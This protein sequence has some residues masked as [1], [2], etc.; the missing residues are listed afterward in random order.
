VGRKLYK[1]KDNFIE[2]KTVDI[3]VHLLTNRERLS[4]PRSYGSWTL[5]PQECASNKTKQK[6]VFAFYKETEEIFV[7]IKNCL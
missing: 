2:Q 1:H 6:H 5:Q 7:T 3:P 4:D